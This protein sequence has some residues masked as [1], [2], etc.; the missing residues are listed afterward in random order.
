MVLNYTQ[1]KDKILGC[2]NGKNSGGLLGAPYEG[3]RQFIDVSYYS[4]ESLKNPPA[5]DDLDLQLINLGVAEVYGR[6]LD[7]KILGEY[8]LSHVIPAWVEYGA[9]K[10]N[11]RQ[12]LNPPIT[13]MV[14]NPFRN[15]CGAYIRSE[16]WA[17]LF[18]GLP[19]EAV[20][21][22]YEDGIVDH[23][24]EG[25]YA[26][27]FCTAMQSAA[28]I[29]SD[30]YELIEIALGY[31]PQ[32]CDTAKAVKRV[33]D[34]YNDGM[35]YKQ[36]RLLLLNEFPCTFGV[37]YSTYNNIDR[38]YPIGK[39]GYDAPLHIGFIVLGLLYGQG[40]YGK[41]LC[42]AVSCG[43][44]TDCTAATLGALLGIMHGNSRLPKEWIE[45]LNN[46]IV[47]ACVDTFDRINLP[48]TTDELTDRILKLIPTFI[49]FENN[50]TKYICYETE[51]GLTLDIDTNRFPLKSIYPNLDG[52]KGC[53][54]SPC[55]PMQEYLRFPYA[56]KFEFPLYTAFLDYLDGPFIQVGEE[57][58]IKIRLYANDRMTT[59]LINNVSV[60]T[61]GGL[62]C[63]P[64]NYYAL[65]LQN[66]V[67]S[68]SE[69]TLTFKT[70]MPIS[71]KL[72]FIV[73]IS[74]QG[75]NCANLMKGVLLISDGNHQDN[76]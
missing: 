9:C 57:K 59:Q 8:W 3:K 18:P 58:K 53:G 24:E 47:I 38:E 23:G 2:W 67:G 7:A 39:P 36:L 4:E 21:Y 13:G 65:S 22:A 19:A 62:T 11:L 61:Q 27:I 54:N 34:C 69:L 20:K 1:L 48:R 30:V 44:D 25:L 64:S 32:D 41:T 56:E 42:I 71:S 75:K 50:G 76:E 73:D 51:H 33:V 70:E 43:E 72:E 31:I 28:F 37:Q 49:P 40:D 46:K 29:V 10:S 68:H 60:Y 6:K 16:L 45:P 66:R 26:E 74:A 35:D 17:C 55:V 15:S 14:D 5:N 63:L 52:V 12:G